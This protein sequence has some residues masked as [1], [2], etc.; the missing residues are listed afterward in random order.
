MRNPKLS[1]AQQR[2]ADAMKESTWQRVDRRLLA[3]PRVTEDEAARLIADHIARRGITQCP[4]PVEMLEPVN[5]GVG[6]GARKPR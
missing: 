4:P 5:Y 6:W 1:L 3:L 2:V